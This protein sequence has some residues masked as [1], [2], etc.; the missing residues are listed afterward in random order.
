M[1]SFSQ[2]PSS[3]N[4]KIRSITLPVRSHP[5]TQRTDQELH[6]LKASEA[7]TLSSPKA[8][9]IRNALYGLGDLYKCLEDL[10]SLPLTRQALA[11]HQ[12]EELLDDSLGYLDFCGSTREAV[13]V[14]KEGVRELKSAIRRRKVGDSSIESNVT[15]YMSLRKRMKKGIEQSFKQI[16]DHKHGGFPLHHLDTHLCAVV[17]VLREASFITNS[18]FRSLSLFLSTPLLKARPASRWSLVSIMVQKGVALGYHDHVNN[19]QEKINVNELESVDIALG[20][21]LLI[22]QS[23]SSDTEDFEDEKV[24][25]AQKKLDDLEGVIDGLENGLE[26]LFRLLIK[27]RVCLLNVISQ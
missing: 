17:R 9:Q 8:S 12:Q 16:L 15:T 25:I 11:Q 22:M 21:L 18:I 13:S 3:R 4:Y 20:N 24:Q 19:I 27:N 26:C 23:S 2:K 1:P 5:T 6:K 10:L 7:V 14:M